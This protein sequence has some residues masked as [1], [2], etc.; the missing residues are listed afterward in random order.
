MKCLS[1]G[2]KMKVMDSR[3]MNNEVFRRYVCKCGERLYTKESIDSGAKK[4]I[5]Q[6]NINR[7]KH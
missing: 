3:T 5:S 6:I 7:Y 1:C 2:S 4:K